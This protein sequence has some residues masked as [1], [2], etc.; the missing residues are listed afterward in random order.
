MKTGIATLWSAVRRLPWF[1]KLL[2]WFYIFIFCG[3]VA[4]KC[5]V[6]FHVLVPMVITA[7]AIVL[8]SCLVE[9]YQDY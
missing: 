3:A 4:S 8:M 1:Y 2:F 5:G 6:S 9:I 7:E